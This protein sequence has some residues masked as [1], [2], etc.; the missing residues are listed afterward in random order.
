MQN[1]R[2]GTHYPARF[3]RFWRRRGWVV[4]GAL[5]AVALVLGL[6]GFSLYAPSAGRSGRLT[7]AAYRTLQLIPLNSGDVD[8]AP[9]QL[10]VARFLIPF[11]AA[12]TAIRALLSLFRDRWRQFLLRFWRGH[13]V[14]CGLSRKGWLLAQGFAAENE[15]VVVIEADKDHALIGHCR[16]D[17][18][19]VLTGDA[20]DPDLL[21]RAGVRRAGHLVAVTDDDGINVEIAVRCQGMLREYLTPLPPSPGRRG[22]RWRADSPGALTCTVHLVDPQLHELARTRELAL[23]EDVPLRMEMFNVFESGARLLWSR[24]GPRR[25]E[26]SAGAAA[27]V[28]GA[29]C[30]THVLI[31]GMGRLGECLAVQAARDWYARSHESQCGASGRLRISVVDREADRKCRTLSLRYPQL[32]GVC[33]L[34]AQ[35]IDVNGPDFYNAA[36]LG[37]GEGFPPVNGVFVCFDDDSLGLRTGLAIH[38]RLLH[39]AAGPTPVVVRT[40]EAGGLA[41]LVELRSGNPA[42]H[43]FANL[44]AFPLLDCTCTPLAIRRGTHETLARGLHEAYRRQQ[45]ALGHTNASNPSLAGWEMLSEEMRESNRA[46]ADGIWRHLAA[47]GLTLVSLEDWDAAFFR[48]TEPEVEEL[49]QMEHGRWVEDMSRRGFK[50]CDGPK[51]LA[52]RLHPAVRPWA[53]LPESERAKTRA[54]VRELPAMLAQAGFQI[55]R[56]PDDGEPA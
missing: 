24:Y 42:A 49:A 15:R 11:L 14:I 36:F 31:I 45:E 13:V 21:R 40:A 7:D 4:I 5:W 27:Q 25:S 37:G 32:D 46:E 35:T 29:R 48:F 2:K 54:N 16:E 18:I 9:W 3:G 22:G 47:I 17:G 33:E 23:E 30:S 26:H 51:D 52:A 20:S 38:R 12:W 56:L 55:A 53:E 6:I 34:A 19:V 39:L 50:A 44:H 8:G 10:E 1:T 41:R 43:T 28:A